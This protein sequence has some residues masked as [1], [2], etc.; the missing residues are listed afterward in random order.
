MEVYGLFYTPSFVTFDW[1]KPH[2]MEPE[3]DVF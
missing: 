1:I 2:G 3:K